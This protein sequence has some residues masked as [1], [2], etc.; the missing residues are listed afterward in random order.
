MREG[1][2]EQRNRQRRGRGGGCWVEGEERVRKKEEG[3]ASR[4]A[5]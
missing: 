3:K 1:Q 5:D 2:D 4:H